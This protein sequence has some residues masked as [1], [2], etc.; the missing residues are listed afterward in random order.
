MPRTFDV[1][2]YGTL[3]DFD[4]LAC[5]LNVRAV[6]AGRLI[7]AK[8]KGHR[9]FALKGRAYPSLARDDASA[10]EGFVFQDCT[11]GEWAKLVHYENADYTPVAVNAETGQG[12]R[13]ARAFL[14]G[15]KHARLDAGRDWSFADWT[16]RD[17]S[18]YMKRLARTGVS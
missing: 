14:G 12:V 10:V 9:R 3:M 6:G 4:V 13:H 15:P 18:A 7:P 17:K 11:P 8:L 2:V 5:V 1:F 16:R